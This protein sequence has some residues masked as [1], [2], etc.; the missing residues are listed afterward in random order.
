[1][2][3]ARRAFD[4]RSFDHGADDSLRI[5]EKLT[6]RAG[7]GRSAERQLPIGPTESFPK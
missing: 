3:S 1:M 6:R 7:S 4:R 2:E 5:R